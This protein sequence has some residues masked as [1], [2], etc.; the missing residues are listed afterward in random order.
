MTIIINKKR[1]EIVQRNSNW[2]WS[3][4][5]KSK[6]KTKL[7]ETRKNKT[8]TKTETKNIK[9]WSWNKIT[10]SIIKELGEEK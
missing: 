9:M 3:K 6:S 8:I 7:I 1:G 5:F 10:F 4:I 2:W